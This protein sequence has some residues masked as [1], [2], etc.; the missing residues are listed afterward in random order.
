MAW[1]EHKEWLRD[2]FG[3]DMD[4]CYQAFWIAEIDFPV[5]GDSRVSGLLISIYLERV[6]LYA[7]FEVQLISQGL[8]I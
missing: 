6:H 2:G 1:K 8:C 4:Y 7:A 3:L 5:F